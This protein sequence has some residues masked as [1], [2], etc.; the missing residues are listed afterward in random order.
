M[1]TLTLVRHGQASYGAADYDRLSELGVRQAE[2]LGRRW[3]ATG[4]RPQVLVSGPMKRQR[5]TVTTAWETARGLGHEL[6]AP[7]IMDELAEYPAF[8][9]LARF[10]PALVRERP[11]LRGLMDSGTALAARAELHD[12]AFWMVIDAWCKDELDTGDIETFGGFV[13]RVRR[14]LEQLIAANPG[15]GRHVVAVTSGGP[16]GVACKLALGIEARSTLSLWR[17][18]RNASVT[19][20]LWRSQDFGWKPGD[21]SLLGFNHV[22]HL[23]DD[24]VTFR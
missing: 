2:A 10:L 13:A 20:L 23:G 16:I 5:D 7:T 17:M 11:E 18:V 9:L 14:G 22:D 4:V 1:G 8:E 6:P 24:L 12:L 15:R 19:Q 21:L 3:A